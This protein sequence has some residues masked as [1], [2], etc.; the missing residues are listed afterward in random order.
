MMSCLYLNDCIF[1]YMSMQKES[2]SPN[3][4]ID[5]LIFWGV[6]FYEIQCILS[7]LQRH[8]SIL[9]GILVF[10]W[11]TCIIQ[12][13]VG[14]LG[15]LVDVIRVPMVTS[16]WTKYSPGVSMCINLHHFGRLKYPPLWIFRWHTETLYFASMH[17]IFLS[18]LVFSEV[19]FYKT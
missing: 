7:H 17:Y 6:F 15:F 1:A 13:R 16:R 11:D 19:F 9:W 12:V 5:Y 10:H 2:G 3:C 18:K 14:I 8:W 4:L